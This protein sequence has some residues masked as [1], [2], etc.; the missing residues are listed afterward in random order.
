MNK[1]TPGPW[2]ADI[3]EKGNR[4][5]S[6]KIGPRLNYDDDSGTFQASI[7]INEGPT[8]GD[9]AQGKGFGT[10]TETCNA[11]AYLI[12]AAPKLLE[13]CQAYLA[14]DYQTLN[15]TVAEKLAQLREYER[16]ASDIRQQIREAV[17]AATQES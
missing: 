16:Q 14:N 6:V 11:N 1:H 5:P 17:A 13:A 15:G 4:Y 12:A 2:E 8:P 10:T 9:V 3:H 7:T